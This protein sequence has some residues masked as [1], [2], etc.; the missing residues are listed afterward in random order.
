MSK[1]EDGVIQLSTAE[2][3]DELTNKQPNQEPIVIDVREVTEYEDGHIPGVPLIPMNEMPTM[4]P[5]MDEAKSYILVCRSGRRSQHTAKYMK[6]QG[7]LNVRNYEGGM[8]E[9]DGEQTFGQEWIVKES[10]ELYE[11]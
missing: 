8:L 10:A 11:K 2:L 3:K 1:V 6:E 4:L 9:W 7:F 5:K